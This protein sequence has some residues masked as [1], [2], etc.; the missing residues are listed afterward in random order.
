MSDFP[1]PVQ[2]LSANLHSQ[3]SLETGRPSY[4]GLQPP[5][6][7]NGTL[8]QSSGDLMGS[9]ANAIPT[10]GDA[11][12]S[13]VAPVS[14]ADLGL[15]FFGSNNVI[16]N[17][18]AIW[19]DWDPTL[20]AQF[21]QLYGNSNSNQPIG[22]GAQ[23]MQQATPRE[24]DI[25]QARSIAHP[26]NQYTVQRVNQ[27]TSG[28]QTVQ[29]GKLDPQASIQLSSV[30][31]LASAQV[32]S[33]IP[34]ERPEGLQSGARTSSITVPRTGEPDAK[35][36]VPANKTQGQQGINSMDVTETVNSPQ[37][38]PAQGNSSKAKNYEHNS[39]VRERALLPTVNPSPILPAGK[40]F[41]IQIGSEL[42]KLS[43]ASIS[44]DGKRRVCS[45]I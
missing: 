43:G 8:S 34:A 32:A 11:D 31:P 42:F 22:E 25:P 16:S 44:S 13:N 15:S 29:P 4:N 28:D 5:L 1:S 9:S 45:S 30:N 37:S 38:S 40:V 20:E 39:P 35:D 23:S 33:Q 7:V 21:S 14:V 26:S 2:A 27:I 36:Q 19:R 6:G 12:A 24:F 41:P 3:S 10:S 18:P 17:G